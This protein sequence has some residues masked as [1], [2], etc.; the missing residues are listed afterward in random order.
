MSGVLAVFENRENLLAA[1]A[2]VKV[3]GFDLEVFSPFADEEL[4]AAA[5]PGPSPVHYLTLLGGVAGGLCGLA[6]TIWTTAQW[7][8]LL[9]GGKPLISI[10]PFLVIA[11]E[12]TILFGSLG[13]LGGF[14]YWSVLLR[15]RHPIPYDKRFS[16]G[17]FGLWVACREADRNRVVN[18]VEEKGAVEW[19]LH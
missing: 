13:A 15:S 14:L 19:Q 8:V 6:L 17:H 3:H 2:H 11:F 16:D 7:P 9:T 12:L 1:A 18:L 10:P 4:V 5:I